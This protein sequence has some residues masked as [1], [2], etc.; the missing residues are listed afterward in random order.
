MASDTTPQLPAI[1]EDDDGE[2]WWHAGH[3]TPNDLLR[4]ALVIVLAESDVEGAWE[5]AAT[6]D[7]H[8]EW[9]RES[10]RD[11]QMERCDSGDLGATPYTVLA[12]SGG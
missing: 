5:S 7:I 11:E 8:R 10:T 2:H 3:D 1:F 9:W 4:L 6:A 12:V